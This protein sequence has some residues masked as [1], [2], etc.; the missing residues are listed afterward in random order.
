MWAPDRRGPQVPSGFWSA[1][2]AVEGAYIGN[3][4]ISMCNGSIEGSEAAGA[5]VPE[6]RWGP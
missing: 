5:V 6:E 1:Q 3:D 2:G 4:A